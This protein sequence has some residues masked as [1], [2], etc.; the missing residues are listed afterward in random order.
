MSTYAQ[1]QTVNEFKTD[2]MS[3]FGLDDDND[4]EG[5]S[6]EAILKYIDD[7]NR[8]F[9]EHRAWRFRLKHRTDWKLPAT[10]VLTNFTTAATTIA[11]TSTAYLPATG[12]I[13]VDGDIISYTANDTVL[14][15]L[16]VTTAEID[17][18]HDA[19]EQV[20]Y[21][22]PV[23]SDWNKV[24]DI[25]VGDIPLQPADIRNSKFPPPYTFW[26]IQLNEPNG[27]LSKYLMYYYNTTREKIY[28]KYGSLATNLTV[29]P[30]T[31]YIEV[32]APYRNYIKEKVF[33]RIY[34]HLEDFD[35]MNVSDAAG[36][37]I[38][39]AAAVYDS[40]QHLSNKVPLRTTWD[41]PGALLYRNSSSRITFN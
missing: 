17:R 41:N 36:E 19:S 1:E 7:S 28:I 25:Y 24:A 3:E 18:N 9:I 29:N 35:S 40:K 14:N 33:A 26:E 10:T 21:L 30:D 20:W 38:L 37:K 6:S 15:I 11:L 13:Y 23:P 22:H 12:K 32:P 2:L 31:T 39:L 16:T 34:K 5:T 8:R 4:N 27:V